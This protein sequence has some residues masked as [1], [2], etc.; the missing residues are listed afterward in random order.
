MGKVYLLE[1][2]LQYLRILKVSPFFVNN[3]VFVDIGCD[4]PA[5]LLNTVKKNMNKCIGIDIAVSPK[6]Y[7]NVAIHQQNIQKKIDLPSSIANTVTM[8]AVLEHME[9]PEQIVNESCRILQ[10][11]GVLLITVPSPRSEPFLNIF[12][13]LKLVR[14]DMI[15]QHHNYFSKNDLKSICKKAGFSQVYVQGFEFGLNNFVRA[16]K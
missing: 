13:K 7:E 9:Y 14:P 8:L 2:I 5:V 16:V 11:N 1:P 15:E 4:E 3:G 10:K 6:K 12:S